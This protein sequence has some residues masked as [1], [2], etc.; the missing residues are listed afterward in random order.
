[1]HALVVACDESLSWQRWIVPGRVAIRCRVHM[2]VL[3]TALG[4]GLCAEGF[5]ATPRSSWLDRLVEGSVCLVDVHV[6]VLVALLTTPS[7]G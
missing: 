1:M 4:R 7:H 2:Y 5:V 6:S 3:D